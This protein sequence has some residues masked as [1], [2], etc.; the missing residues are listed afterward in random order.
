MQ[1]RRKFVRWEDTS[2]DTSYNKSLSAE[3]IKSLHSKDISKEGMRFVTSEELNESDIINLKI[4]LTNESKIIDAKGRVAW[5][6]K[7][8]STKHVGQKRFNIGIEFLD[9]NKESSRII[10]MHIFSS[11]LN[12]ANLA[13]WQHHIINKMSKIL[14]QTSSH[15]PSQN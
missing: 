12:M 3:T 4:G 14:N 1:E 5:I 9:L 11:H 8:I 15:A 6:K 7:T 10:G 13:Y 2:I